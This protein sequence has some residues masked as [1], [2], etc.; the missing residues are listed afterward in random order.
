MKINL[1]YYLYE[2]NGAF[3]SFEDTFYNLSKFTNHNVNF[4]ILYEDKYMLAQ[5]KK[6]LPKGSG[7]C[8]LELP[9]TPD[10]GTNLYKRVAV[11]E[12]Y[13]T[14]VYNIKGD[15][16][17][18][19]SEVIRLQKANRIK[20][21]ASQ[22]MLLYP[23]FIYKEQGLDKT[24]YNDEQEYIKNNDVLVICNKF[25]TKYVNNSFVW[26]MQFSKERIEQLKKLVSNENDVLCAE[27]YYK[28]KMNC[29]NIEPFSY[30]K[31]EYYR[32]DKKNE[33]NC[34]TDDGARYYENIG[35]LMF[36]FVL[37]GKESSY[38]PRNK[39]FDDGLTE[40]MNYLGYDDNQSYLWNHKDISYLEKRLFMDKDN[41]LL[42][43]FK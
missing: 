43:L 24:F 38:S 31:Y 27:E 11:R 23:A 20:Q 5:F 13:H 7:I 26:Y 14:M 15:I 22:E 4:F 42:S 12:V 32:Y 25:N 17:I 3:T 6:Y 19:S 30:K 36:E 35:K 9:K 40:F 1:I 37:L 21:S 2:V 16:N 29:K 34:Y 39:Q 28:N 18:I 41:K 8:L 33:T 10:E